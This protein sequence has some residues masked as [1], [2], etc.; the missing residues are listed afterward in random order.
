MLDISRCKVPQ[1]RT[2]FRMVEKMAAMKL[3]QL[4]LYTEHTFAFQNHPQVW[5]AASP[6]TA[7]EIL[8]LDA[9]CRKHFIELVPNF[10]S[11]GHWERWLK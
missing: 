1:M 11:F 4:Q 8:E 9:H 7:E 10:N 5:K 3:N 6:M 2:L